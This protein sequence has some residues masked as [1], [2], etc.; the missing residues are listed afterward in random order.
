[1]QEKFA[2]SIDFVEKIDFLL[3]TRFYNKLFINPLTTYAG[4][5]N[6]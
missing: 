1:M 3:I 2:K 5:L 4:F 6:V